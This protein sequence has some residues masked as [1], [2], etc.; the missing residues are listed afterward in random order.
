MNKEKNLW[1]W[2]GINRSCCCALAVISPSANIVPASVEKVL[3]YNESLDGIIF[4]A[5]VYPL[6]NPPGKLL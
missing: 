5:S 2:S 3:A 6:V 4:L 1:L